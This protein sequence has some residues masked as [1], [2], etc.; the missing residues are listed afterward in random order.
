MGLNKAEYIREMC[1]PK[2]GKRSRMR[3]RGQKKKPFTENE[4]VVAT[5]RAIT[6]APKVEKLVQKAM[7]KI[8]PGLIEAARKAAKR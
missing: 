3:A 1:L 2:L 6:A 4:K 8:K 7:D 5:A